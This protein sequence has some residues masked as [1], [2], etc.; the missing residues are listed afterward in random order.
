MGDVAISLA[1]HFG[2]VGARISKEK[3]CYLYKKDNEVARVQKTYETHKK[4]RERYNLLHALY[5]S[6]FYQ[7]DRISCHVPFVM[8]GRETYAI[9]AHIQGRD[10]DY[11]SVDDMIMAMQSLAKFHKVARAVNMPLMAATTKMPPLGEVFAKDSAFL[12]KTL[13][14][15]ERSSKLSDFDVMF[16]KNS[17]KYIEDGQ[18]SAQVL[19]A[20]GYHLM[21]E[22]AMKNNHLCHNLLKEEFMPIYKGECYLTNFCDVVIGTQIM[23]IIALLRRYVRRSNREILPKQLLEAYDRLLPLPDDA[24]KIVYAGLVH[25]WQFVKIAQQYYNKK[26]GWTPV[27]IMSRM[28]TLVEEQAALDEYVQGLAAAE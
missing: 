20:T 27:G 10:L 11:N 17:A 18:K 16:I 25:P 5:D 3:G 7:T 26:R 22:T 21:Y 13:R 15:V 19:A 14:Q 2:I 28:N 8:I 12:L 23:D 9:S 6:G 4:I 1:R 24:S